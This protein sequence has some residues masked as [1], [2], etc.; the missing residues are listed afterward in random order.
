MKLRKTEITGIEAV[1]K[2]GWDVALSVML[3]AIL[4]PLMLIIAIIVKLQDGGKV[5]YKQRRVTKG[6]KLFW[7]YKFR[8]MHKNSEKHGAVL[9]TENDERVCQTGQRLSLDR[10][11]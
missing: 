6:G 5:I 8:S 4:S 2:R 7:I 3:L 11:D 1:V 9:A 10:S